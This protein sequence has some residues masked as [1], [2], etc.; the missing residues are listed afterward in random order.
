MVVIDQTISIIT[1]NMLYLKYVDIVYQL[2]TEISRM[3]KN[4]GHKS[5]FSII[6]SHFKYKI[7]KRLK[8]KR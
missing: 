7:S 3:D 5:M 1:L 6:K 2:K 8:V 4:I